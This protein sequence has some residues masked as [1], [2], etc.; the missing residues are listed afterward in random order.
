MTKNICISLDVCF[1]Y[2]RYKKQ[3]VVKN[4]LYRRGLLLSVSGLS[5]PAAAPRS[6]LCVPLLP[7]QQPDETRSCAGQHATWIRQSKRVRE[8]CTEIWAYVYLCIITYSVFHCPVVSVFHESCVQP[9]S[10]LLAVLSSSSPTVSP[11]PTAHHSESPALEPALPAW[12][13]LSSGSL[14]SV[15]TCMHKYTHSQ[16]TNSFWHWLFIN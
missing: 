12:C 10:S 6:Q 1:M 4:V 13:M 7:A 9:G 11:S 5:M 3:V 15:H 2:V 8:L 14:C 16:I